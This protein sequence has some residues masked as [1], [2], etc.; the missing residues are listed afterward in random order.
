MANKKTMLGVHFTG[1]GRISLDKVPCPEPH[2]QNVLVR[3]RA[4]AICGTDRENLEAEGQARIPGHESAGEIVGVDKAGRVKVGDRV[5]INCHIT[6][7]QCEH[8]LR[9]DLF[10]CP[11]LEVVGFDI[12]GGF[13]EYVLVPESTCMVL[14][15]DISYEAGALMVDV[16]GTAYRGVRRAQPKPRDRVGIWGAG[17]IGLEAL[18]TAQWLGCEVAILDPNQFRLDMARELGSAIALNPAQDDV[19]STLM[20]WTDGNGL[21]IAY[22]C[23]G[24]EAAIHQA[25]D[26][27]K[28]RGT[29]GII[30]VSHKLTVNPWDHFI[31]RELTFIG[32]RNFTLPEFDG[33]LAMI[34]HGAPVEKVV[35]NRFPIAEAQAAFELFKSAE[36]GKIV[37]T[38]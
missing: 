30:G 5:A 6:C 27:L 28:P 20:D 37:F 32:S 10:L 31:C 7:G 34:R 3:I 38:G 19:K 16:F 8:C 21:D 1:A 11:R 35:T 26:A 23:V 9:G 17:P 2:D 22:D 33:M 24:N 29:L 12:D 18:I 36:C 25:L 13:A 15:N 14:P 4:A